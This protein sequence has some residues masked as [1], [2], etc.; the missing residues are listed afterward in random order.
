M[1]V[2]RARWVLPV[3]A[4]PVRDGA[5]AVEAGR[6]AWVGR[7]SMA[8]AGER[9]DL[10]DALLMPALVNA[11]TH[12]D[13]THFRGLLEGLG[14]LD[15]IRTLT[16]AKRE[17][18]TDESLLDAA[19]LGIVEGLRAGIAT[20]G[21]TSDRAA[22]A[23]AMAEGGVR[24]TAYLETFGPDP[25]HADTA[26]ADLDVRVE[27][28]AARLAAMPGGARVRLG[29]SPHAPYSVSDALYAAVARLAGARA[30]PVAVHIA[31]SLDEERLVVAG[32]GAFADF[33]R[34]RGIPVAPRAASPLALLER[35]GVLAQRPLLIHAVRVRADDRRRAADAG[36]GVAH[37]PCSN[38]KLGHGVAPLREW[39]DTGAAV[40]LGSD[41]M[42]SNNRMHLLEEGRVAALHQAARFGRPDAVSP[43]EILHAATLGGAGALGLAHEIGSLEP[44][45]AADLAAFP[46]GGLVG[47]ADLDPVATAVYAMGDAQATLVTVDGEP[48]VLDGRVLAGDPDLAARAAAAAARLAEWRGARPPG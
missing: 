38:A 31:E 2:W 34:G 6:I 43:A 41:S 18:A 39:L 19:R 14:F 24:G 22:S 20:F 11:H 16:A 48:R 8:P 40:G 36:C 9:R 46:L 37:C 13:L 21:D 30:L 47:A 23:L 33:L 29:V 5:V 4:P 32:E 44:G 10:G 42:A 45:K 1:I 15:W 12:L 25:A 3:D 26:V 35:T 7:A 27:S 17:V 28:L